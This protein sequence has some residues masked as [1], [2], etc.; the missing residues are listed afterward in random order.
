MY[1][2]DV[3]KSLNDFWS[4]QGCFMEQPYDMEMG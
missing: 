4:K 2:Q 3:I 1:L